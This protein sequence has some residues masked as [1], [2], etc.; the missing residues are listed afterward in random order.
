MSYYLLPHISNLLNHTNIDI[1]FGEMSN[2]DTHVSSKTSQNYLT[3]LKIEIEKYPNT[4]DTYKKFT[5]TYEYIHSQIPDQKCSVSKYKPLSRSYFKFIEIANV[6]DILNYYYDTPIESFHICEGPG[7]FIE[8]LSILRN[9]QND[10]YYGMTLVN[11]DESTPGWKKSQKFLKNNKNVIIETGP[12]NTGNILNP[13]NYKFCAM[14]YLN[15]FDIMTGDGGFDF[16]IDF[17]NQ[18]NICNKLILGQIIY[19]L[20]LQKQGGTFILKIFDM[21]SKSTQDYIFL[22]SLFYNKVYI[23]KPQTSRLANSEKYIICKDFKCKT[24]RNYSH[25]FYNIFDTNNFQNTQKV[26]NSFFSNNLP[27]FYI[28]KIEEILNVLCQFQIN[29]INN[30]IQL[31]RYNKNDNKSKIYEMI[32]TNVS[33]CVQ[34]C[35]KNNIPYNKNLIRN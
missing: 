32:K 10:K 17:N 6:F 28:S 20:T 29:V 15:Q 26:I 8:A 25:I 18:E 23:F 1:S 22:L 11:D 24:T 16:S 33:K 9:N 2:C 19:A 30:T 21:F 4:W 31:I 12:D 3:T 13:T 5:N 34:W 27:Y 35:I 7:G 14:K